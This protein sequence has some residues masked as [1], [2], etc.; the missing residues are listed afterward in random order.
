M[1][2]A[3]RIPAPGDQIAVTSVLTQDPDMLREMPYAASSTTPRP[4]RAT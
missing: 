3:D 1:S 4:A 2:T